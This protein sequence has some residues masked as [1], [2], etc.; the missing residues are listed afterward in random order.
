MWGRGEEGLRFSTFQTEILHR[1]NAKNLKP[2]CVASH[3]FVRFRRA[4]PVNAS[5]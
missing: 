1:L 5:D 2:Y 3:M 4:F